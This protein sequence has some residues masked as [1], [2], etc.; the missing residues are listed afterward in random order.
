MLDSPTRHLRVHIAVQPPEG[1]RYFLPRRGYGMGVCEHRKIIRLR[2][3]NA[4]C[5][6]CDKH[7]THEEMKAEHLTESLPE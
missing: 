4:Y 3:G 1:V 5:V 6:A 2:T 7:Y